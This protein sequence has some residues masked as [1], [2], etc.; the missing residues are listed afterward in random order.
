VLTALSLGVK[1][2]GRKADQSPPSS[3]GVMSVGQ[4][5]GEVTVIKMRSGSP[6]YIRVL[7]LTNKNNVDLE[8]VGRGFVSACSRRNDN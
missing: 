5:R 7:S 2:P 8:S 3:A 4:G 6:T 1:W